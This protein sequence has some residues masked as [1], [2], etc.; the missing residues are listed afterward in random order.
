M[1]TSLLMVTPLIWALITSLKNLKEIFTDPMN[2][3]PKVWCWSN[4]RNIFKIIPLMTY[5]LNSVKVTLL[6]LIGTLITC[7]MAAYA[8][9][10]LKFPGRDYLF[11]LYLST[12]MI[13]NQVTLVPVFILMKWF[14]LI[15]NHLSL[16]LLGVFSSFNA[17][18]TFLL[19]QFF[20]G[21]P[22]E[23]E[24]AAMLDGCNF[25]TI[26]SRIILPLSKPGLATLGIFALFNTWNDYLYPLVFINNEK[27]RTLTLGLAILRGD[28]D[29]QW[30]SVM[31]ASL[32]SILPILVLFLFAQ[33]FFIEGV[34]FSGIKG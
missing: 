11:L 28:L 19:R 10:R 29:V 20:L 7:S 34:A 14:G 13:P 4:Y 2:L 31:A 23:L 21:I 8:F 1:G 5:F 22:H 12:F 26:F 17:Y 3:I 27:L 18:G 30:N 16:I 33:K 25:F 9:A 32:L 6:T 15:D 24:E